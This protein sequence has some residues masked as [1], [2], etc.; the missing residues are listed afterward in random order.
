MKSILFILLSIL[1]V[2]PVAG[3]YAENSGN[4]A[5]LKTKNEIRQKTQE[6]ID[7]YKNEMKLQKEELKKQML[8]N[9]EKTKTN[10]RTQFNEI[11]DEQKLIRME[12]IEESLNKINA[13]R[14]DHFTRVLERLGA[15]LVKLETHTATLAAE[16][17]DITGAQSAIAKAKTE[18]ANATA[19]VSTQKNKVYNV[20]DGTQETA[21]KSNYGQLFKSLQEDL[22]AVW[23]NIKTAK[24]AVFAVLKQ[25][26]PNILEVKPTVS[27]SITVTP[28][29]TPAQ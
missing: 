16:G 2:L 11:K 21:L 6:E 23:E 27:P 3:V 15:I 22:R 18:I 10:I 26:R 13:R 7:K 5:G 8:E 17:K 25:L 29:V 4:A 20:P 24:D 12:R 14:S 9:R 28:I 19:A 1:F